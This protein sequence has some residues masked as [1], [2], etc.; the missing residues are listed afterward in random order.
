[1]NLAALIVRSDH[2]ITMH[3][4]IL[5]DL[6]RGREE[7]FP[8]NDYL[9]HSVAGGGRDYS[10]LVNKWW[11]VNTPATSA[12]AAV[13][14]GLK[15]NFDE[16]ILCG[17]PLTGGDGYAV[18]SALK[19]VGHMMPDSSVLK[20][21]QYGMRLIAM[22]QGNKVFSMSGYTAELFGQPKIDKKRFYN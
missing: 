12:G 20:E 2:I 21:H 17:C 11:A 19:G 16:I 4:E 13:L 18:D 14:I 7:V 6:L 22:N 5:P 10:P 15:L 3:P 8:G 1:V 9:V